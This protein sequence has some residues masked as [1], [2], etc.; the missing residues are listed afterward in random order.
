MT[1]PEFRELVGA[2][3][4]LGEDNDFVRAAVE[5]EAEERRE[6]DQKRIQAV[7]EDARRRAAGWVRALAK[8]G[9]ETRGLSPDAA[10]ISMALAK[11]LRPWAEELREEGFGKPCAPFPKDPM[12][13][14]EWIEMQIK[15]DREQWQRQ[16]VS[17]PDAQRELE[18]LAGIAGLVVRIE[19]RYVDYIRPD[20]EH[21]QMAGAFPG[22]FLERLAQ[23]TDHVA[24]KTAF[25]PEVL[26]GFVLTG[27]QPMISRVRIRK[28]EG[29]CTIPGDSIP[30]RSVTLEF[31]AADI[32][33][34]EVRTLHAEI[35]EF[36][37]AADK[38][39]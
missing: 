9:G 2:F 35:R 11:R 8:E 1:P 4:N 27:L 29:G 34:E 39:R 13:A 18:R 30:C 14:A 25:R 19:V 37:G 32:S 36:F 7:A 6:L 38:E 24:E 20:V 12:A 3:S 31:Y 15:K 23:E 10:F 17:I 16:S 28:T 22:T 33:Y 21:R 5:R 26:T